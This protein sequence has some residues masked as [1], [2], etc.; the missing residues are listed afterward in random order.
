MPVDRPTAADS[1]LAGSPTHTTAVRRRPGRLIAIFRGG[2]GG[3][4]LMAI[5]YSAWLSALSYIAWV[6]VLAGNQ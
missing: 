6:N 1:P 5:V 2:L 4:V 3:F